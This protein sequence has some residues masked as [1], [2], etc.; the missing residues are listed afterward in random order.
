[1]IYRLLAINIDGTLLNPR[2]KLSKTTKSAI[3]FVRE[4]GIYVT[5]VTSR[6]FQS[7]K[8]V[9]DALKL[10]SI[11]VTNSGAFVSSSLE[12]PVYVKRF[13]EKQTEELV[14]F[15][16]NYHCNIRISHEKFSLG[17]RKKLQS[18]LVAKAVL[19]NVDPLFYPIQFVDSLS[20]SLQN[21]PLA[22]PKIDLVFAEEQ[23]K[24]SAVASLKRMFL[25]IDVIVGE[26]GKVELVPVGVS[27]GN[28]LKKL[29]E[30]LGI[31]LQE[32]VVIGD[33]V[34]DID[35]IKRAG[36][37]VAMWNAPVE[38]KRAA[39]WVTRSN[40]QNGV[41]YVIVEHFRKQFPLPFLRRYKILR[42]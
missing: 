16:E 40:S 37:G 20:Q 19:S 9:A 17:N 42:K 18:N 15:L 29:G 31:S 14:G 28:A 22:A 34:T 10:D 12:Q 11:L 33:S 5:L 1:M 32:M 3:D 39:D 36:L 7:A 25:H 26:E 41:S 21:Q 27:K 13:T 23:E 6:N 24:S 4:K 38:V 35:I 30:T 8:K 2:G